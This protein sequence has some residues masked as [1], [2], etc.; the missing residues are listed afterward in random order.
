MADLQLLDKS[1]I[2]IIGIIQLLFIIFVFVI[3]YGLV[4]PL[5]VQ[6]LP[7]IIN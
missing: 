7:I 6:I 3:Y 2:R 5:T 4:L 1:K